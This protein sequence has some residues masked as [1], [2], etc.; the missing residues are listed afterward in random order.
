MQEAKAASALDHPHICTISEIDETP[1]GQS[2]LAMAYYEGETLKKKVH[3]GCLT[4]DREISP[5]LRQRPP[6][7]G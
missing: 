4:T 5:S 2:F 7:R 1:E 3:R 6:C